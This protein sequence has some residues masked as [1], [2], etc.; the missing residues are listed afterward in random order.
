MGMFFQSSQFLLPQSTV[1]NRMCPADVPW[2]FFEKSVKFWG[3]SMDF[4]VF[5]AESSH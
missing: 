1:L 3:V 2:L 4:E 5:T